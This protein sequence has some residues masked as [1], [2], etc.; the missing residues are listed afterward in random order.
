MGKIVGQGVLGLI[1]TGVVGWALQLPPYFAAKFTQIVKGG[2]GELQYRGQVYYRR[3]VGLYW[4]YTSPVEKRIWITKDRVVIYEPDIE[5]VTIST[6]RRGLNLA[7]LLRKAKQ[8]SPGHYTTKVEGREYNFTYTNRLEEI[9]YLDRL[10][11]LVV[12]KF[13]NPTKNPPP[14]HLF[15][16]TYPADVDTIYQQ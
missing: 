14:P 10:G 7:Q 1:L 13:S 6:R 2:E 5:Q 12:I 8:L 3:G 15:T 16:P 11:N 9:R 4:H